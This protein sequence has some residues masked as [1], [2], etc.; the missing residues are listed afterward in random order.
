MRRT[1][2][3]IMCV[4]V[5]ARLYLHYIYMYKSSAFHTLDNDDVMTKVESHTQWTHEINVSC[6]V[7]WAKHVKFWRLTEEWLSISTCVCGWAWAPVCVCVCSFVSFLYLP[8]F[9]SLL[10]PGTGFVWISQPNAIKLY[11]TTTTTTKVTKSKKNPCRN[12]R[13]DTAIYYLYWNA[14]QNQPRHRM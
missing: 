6:S 4:Y 7:A 1:S 13:F 3:C 14:I 12:H 2:I 9:L 5:P 11:S 10:N 8:S